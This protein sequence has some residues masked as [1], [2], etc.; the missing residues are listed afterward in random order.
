MLAIL[1]EVSV[2]CFFTS[3]LIVLV[4][5]L[6]R[7]LGRIPGRGL[8][9]LGMMG[10]GLFT[11][12][13]Y[14][15]IRGSGLDMDGES[16]RL[17]TWTDWSL[18]VALALAIV[19]VVLYLRRPDTVISFFF[20]PMVLG[21][22]A[23]AV[24][25]RGLPAFS[26][27]EAV[28]VWRSLHALSMVVGTVAVLIGFLAGLMYQ[29]QSWR[30]KRK[31]AGSG[32]RLPTLE[33]LGLMIR[34]CLVTS[35]IAVGLGVVAGIVMNL[36]RW[37]QVGWTEG[38]VLFSGLLFSWLFVATLLE[39]FYTPEQRDRKV[40]FLTLASFGFLVLAMLSLMGSG[41][42]QTESTPANVSQASAIPPRQVAANPV[43]VTR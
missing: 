37:G 13:T 27:N 21:L 2:T 23:L 36:N 33:T 40:L 41:H 42:G 10:L 4:L 34:R 14:V 1:R 12:V 31:W 16:A 25:M 3:Y 35:T 32:L 39:F 20:L 6:L 18:M 9:V 29:L 15:V 7:L 38:G 11:H 30:L 19:F 26:R 5:E 17:S 22:I 8:A 24:A 43:G 28:E